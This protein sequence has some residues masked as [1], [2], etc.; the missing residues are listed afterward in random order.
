MIKKILQLAFSVLLV[1]SSVGA[2]SH[3][4]PPPSNATPDYA[5]QYTGFDVT[6]GVGYSGATI[7]HNAK[8]DAVLNAVNIEH[9]IAGVGVQGRIGGTYGFYKKWIVGLDVYGQYNS[10]KTTMKL[11]AQFSDSTAIP[12]LGTALLDADAILST[13][14]KLDANIGIDVRLGVVVGT[15]NLFFL[16][17]GPDWI[18]YKYSYFTSSS[19]SVSLNS[20]PLFGVSSST[21]LNSSGFQPGIRFGAGAE[22]KF[23]DHWV[24]KEYFSYSWYSKISLPYLDEL[25]KTFSLATMIFSAGYLF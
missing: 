20:V 23:W 13:S 1:T 5:K 12:L 9:G 19:A 7:K 17:L 2:R 24:F 21:P 14:N 25:T 6:V 16:T 11:S 15:S 22:Q 4:S 10:G 3:S 8:D 18:H